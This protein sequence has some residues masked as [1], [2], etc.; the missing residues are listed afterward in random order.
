MSG[1]RPHGAGSGKEMAAT[2]S[3][4]RS[5]SVPASSRSARRAMFWAAV[6]LVALACSFS[7]WA[8]SW[9]ALR[10]ALRRSRRRRRSSAW[11]WVR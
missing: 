5:D 9:A 10:S 4:A 8:I 6:A 7:D 1:V 2:L 11:R 3:S